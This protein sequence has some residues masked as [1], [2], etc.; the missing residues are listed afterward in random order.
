MAYY[1]CTSC[2]RRFISAGGMTCVHCG[3]RLRD[4]TLVHA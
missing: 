3:G 2:R 4:L 1:E